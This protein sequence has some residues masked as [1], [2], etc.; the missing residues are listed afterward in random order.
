MTCRYVYLALLLSLC[1]LGNAHAGTVL[2]NLPGTGTYNTFGQFLTTSTWEAV[3]LTTSA[4]TE[5]F[6]SFSGYFNNPSLNPTTLEGGI[7]SD[8]SANPGTL[9]SAFNNV[10]IPASL[11]TPTL[12][13]LTTVS[14]FTLQPSTTYWFVVH[15]A[16]QPL[17]WL[18]DN[19]TNGTLPT[20]AAGFTL[21]GYRTSTNSGTAWSTPGAGLSNY[22]VQIST[23]PEPAT[24]T[25]LGSAFL[26]LGG[27][28]LLRRRRAQGSSPPC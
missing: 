7:F 2:N 16:V 14:G 12:E 19:S 5:T 11:N 10:A 28:Q 20:A 22:T 3:G 4:V 17:Q 25:L 23:T 6:G 26:L 18:Q 21:A 15:D 8:S 27:H 24:L 1:A 13:T 9:L